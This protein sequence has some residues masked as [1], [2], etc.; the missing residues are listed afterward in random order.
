MRPTPNTSS[1]A[2]RA[3]KNL[4]RHFW[5]TVV[6]DRTGL[7]RKAL[8]AGKLLAAA[9]TLAQEIK[10]ISAERVGILLPPGAGGWVANLAVALAGKSSV[11]LNFTTGSA[12]AQKMIEKAQLTTVISAAAMREKAHDFPW[13]SVAFFDLKAFLQ[14][15]EAQKKLTRHFLQALFLPS[16]ILAKLWRVETR[17]EEATL[18][19]T[20]GSTGDPKGIP[21][22][23]GNILS[24][25]EQI[26]ATG[27][28]PPGVRLLANLPLFH[29]F[30]LTVTLWYSLVGRITAVTY[31]TPLEPHAVGQVVE[32]EKVIGVVSTPSFFQ[33]YLRQ[34]PVER[35]QSL[36]WVVAGAEKTPR[37]L[38]ERWQAH[39]GSVYL[40]GYGLTETSPVVSVNLPHDNQ[41]GTVGR[42]LP[43]LQ[44]RVSDPTTRELITT[45]GV[46]G[47]LEFKGPNVFGG[48]LNEPELNREMLRDGW[49]WTGDLGHLSADGRLTVD[50]RLKR[51]SKIAGEMVPHGAVEEA[52]NKMFGWENEERPVVAVASAP[53]EHKGEQLVVISTRPLEVQSLREKLHAAGLPNLWIPKKIAKT[54]TIPLLPSG[55]LDLRKLAEL[56]RQA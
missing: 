40:E 37:G 52:I 29:S 11:N 18:L 14:S 33:M 21:L 34:V 7:E 35:F 19:F 31:P 48:Y 9:A 24:N 53:D 22:T 4:R 16:W 3:L 56:A 6:I 32:E 51:F 17:N 23:H 30:G 43:G 27:L 36:Q 46:Q 50:G 2:R 44:V 55:K 13:K 54:D 42:P 5:R 39:F 28:L 8:T 47:V 20:S 41:V 49:L 10:K 38:H 1:V 45:P 15:A 12:A 26:Q 25:L